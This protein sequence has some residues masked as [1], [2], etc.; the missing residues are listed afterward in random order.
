MADTKMI[1][2][3]VYHAAV[4]SGLTV[5]YSMLAKRFA[6]INTGNPSSADLEDTLK[7]AGMI[8]AAEG[9]RSWLV[10]QKIIPENIQV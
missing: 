8:A 5:A 10:A 1:V 6:K 9:T 4:L 7:L 2:N 3:T